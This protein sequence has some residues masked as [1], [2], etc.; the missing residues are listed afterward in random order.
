MAA[1]KKIFDETDNRPVNVAVIVPDVG[2]ELEW[3]TVNKQLFNPS[4]L[5]EQAVDAVY[6]KTD[7]ESVLCTVDG[8]TLSLK[9]RGEYR[10]D[11]CLN[12]R[13]IFHGGILPDYAVY[14]I[15][16]APTYWDKWQADTLPREL[17]IKKVLMPY[18]KDLLECCWKLNSAVWEQDRKGRYFVRHR[19]KRFYPKDLGD[20]MKRLKAKDYSDGVQDKAA[21]EI[22]VR[23]HPCP[24]I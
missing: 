7:V 23:S 12:G 1:K 3:V 20:G 8:N 16:L 18:L 15:R 2:D 13:E 24:G 10:M 9:G 19:R 4:C 14:E 11:L 21:V 6:R 5:T 17:Q 22:F